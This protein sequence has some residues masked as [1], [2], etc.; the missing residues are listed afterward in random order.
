VDPET[1]Q[2]DSE[3][4]AARLI[5]STLTTCVQENMNESMISKTI[6]ETVSKYPEWGLQFKHISIRGLFSNHENVPSKIRAY[7]KPHPDFDTPGHDLA[8]DYW[9]EQLQPSY[10]FKY[11]FGSKKQIVTPVADTLEWNIPSPPDF[12]HFSMV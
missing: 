11:T 3:K 6:L 10:F 5:Q 2:Y 4:A 9:V 8:A 1:N 7:E 12:H